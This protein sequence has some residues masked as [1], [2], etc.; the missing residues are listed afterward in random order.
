[1][2]EIIDNFD[3][4]EGTTSINSILKSEFKEVP[5]KLTENS[6]FLVLMIF[7]VKFKKRNM[8]IGTKFMKR[9]IELAKANGKDIFLT[10]DSSYAENT[11]MNKSLLTKW[12]KKLGFINKK[13]S[14]FRTRNTMTYYV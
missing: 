6:E 7:V 5:F 14:D 9:L 1:I 8:G 12:Y 3:I 4:I 10:A 11:D 13:N 2:K